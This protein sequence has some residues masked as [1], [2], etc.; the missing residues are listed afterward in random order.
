MRNGFRTHAQ[1]IAYPKKAV[2]RMYKGF[3][4]FWLG[5]ALYVIYKPGYRTALPTG[6]ATR[7]AL[8]PTPWTSLTGAVAAP[9]LRPPLGFPLREFPEH[10]E[11]RGLG[12]YAAGMK[13][14]RNGPLPL[15]DTV[16]GE[17]LCR[18][19]SPWACHI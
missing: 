1:Y 16:L 11:N 7:P 17:T 6:F 13:A 3:P 9:G 2:T 10:P 12:C 5:Q 14:K 8:A 18:G 19:R 15:I 4:A